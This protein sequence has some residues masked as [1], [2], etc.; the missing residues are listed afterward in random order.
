MEIVTTR[1]SPGGLTSWPP[2][3]PERARPHGVL[4]PWGETQPSGDPAAP[5][6]AVGPRA[7]SLRAP[8]IVPSSPRSLSSY[9]L[10]AL[11]VAG[12]LG[13]ASSMQK[14]HSFYCRPAPPHVAGSRPLCQR[15]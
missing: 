8:S 3:S 13:L 9:R 14:A 4:G 2:R 6:A 15:C 1:T 5:Q 11:M 12:G 7:G 10:T